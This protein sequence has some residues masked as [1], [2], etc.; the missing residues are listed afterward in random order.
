MGGGAVQPT[1]NSACYRLAAI[2][3]QLVLAGSLGL[4]L[5]GCTTLWD[6]VSSHDF[7]MRDLF[8][9][10]DPFEV[11]KEGTKDNTDGNERQKALA[12][13]VE[14]SQNG[15]TKEQQDYVVGILVKAA[16]TERD[17]LCRL[18]AIRSLGRF[19]D[20]RAAEAIETV[21]L[22]D[23]KFGR[24]QNS[25]IR[26]RCL[27]SLGETGGPVALHRLVLVAKEP[28][29]PAAKNPLVDTQEI[30]DRRLTAVRGLGH[31]KE[32]EAIAALAY[33]LQSEKDIALRDRAHEALEA[34]TGKHFPM[35]APEWAAYMPGANPIQQAG[36]KGQ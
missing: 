20:P 21:Y 18:S 7:K 26:Q 29:A 22:E 3:R 35:D 30:L 17:S 32:P 12:A 31:F 15:G 16:T 23:L 13:L 9:A 27:V 33:V 10:K 1:N 34:T 2:A 36:G 19:K 11:L 28:P 24:E 6:Q 14:P 8:V 4:T 5:C 25:L